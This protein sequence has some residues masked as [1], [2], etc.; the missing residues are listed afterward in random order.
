MMIERLMNE[1]SELFDKYSTKSALNE[2]KA[3]GEI[4]AKIKLKKAEID[5]MI[6]EK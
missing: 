4:L 6:K 5:K 1:L 2:T 3:T